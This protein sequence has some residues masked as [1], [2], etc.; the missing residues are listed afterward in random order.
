MSGTHF[1]HNKLLAVSLVLLLLSGI[2][3]S[4]WFDKWD[5]FGSGSSSKDNDKDSS[6]DRAGA[7]S[8]GTG[9]RSGTDSGTGGRS[10]SDSGSGS[11]RGSG[12][13]TGIFI[14]PAG[15]CPPGQIKV[16]GICQF[17]ALGTGS[18]STLNAAL[19]AGAGPE[20]NIGQALFAMCGTIKSALAIGFMFLAVLAAIVYAL[21]QMMGAETRARASVWA[22]SMLVGAIFGAL[23]YVLM[24]M[25]L[26]LLLNDPTMDVAKA[27]S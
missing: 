27:C 20:G 13:G 3:F 1:S 17:T 6:S 23:I 16:G 18:S 11:G 10:G 2:T 24:P 21:G 22:T 7:D 14:P 5:W 12:T 25:V 15:G 9:G 8:S 26:D 19:N 4:G